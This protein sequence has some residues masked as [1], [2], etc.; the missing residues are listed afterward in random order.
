MT[1]TTNSG[2]TLNPL[3]LDIGI[4]FNYVNVKFDSQYVLFS[5]DNLRKRKCIM[6]I[7]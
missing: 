7:V 6:S 5:L 1:G 4:V 2:V 3:T